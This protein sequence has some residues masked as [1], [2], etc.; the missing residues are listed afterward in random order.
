M[1]KKQ[2]TVTNKR[3]SKLES[4]DPGDQLVNSDRENQLEAIRKAVGLELLAIAQHEAG[5]NASIADIERILS[6]MLT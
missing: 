4:I 2:R 6:R 1:S 5:E 3:I